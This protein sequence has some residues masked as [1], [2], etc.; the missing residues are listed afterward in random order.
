MPQHGEPKLL[1]TDYFIRLISGLF[2][3][4]SFLFFMGL[5]RAEISNI[6]LFLGI[7]AEPN[8][9]ID[10]S[11]ES[12]M[13][14]AA[15]NDQPNTSTGCGGRISVGG[16]T[17]GPC[18]NPI[19][20][21]LGYFDPKKCYTYN[22]SGYFEPKTLANSTNHSCSGA[23][24]GNMMNWA[25]MTAIDMF[26][27]TM[28]GGNRVIDTKLLTI[29]ERAKKTNN[30]GWFPNKVLRSTSNVAPSSVT[31]W[32]DSPIYIRNTND[33]SADDGWKVT[34]GTTFGGSDKGTYMVRVK[35]CDPTVSLE[36][37]CIKYTSTTGE[38]YYKPEGL[39]QKNSESK[40]FGLMSY[41]NNNTIQKNG[42]V[43]R[44][45]MK[46]VGLKM[47]DTSGNL[48]DNPN[49]EWGTDGL[50][51]TDPDNQ[52]GS[53]GILISG[54]INYINKFTRM[55]GHKGFDPVSELFYEA[56]HYF[57]G[58]TIAH[59]GPTSEY[60]PSNDT[61][62]GR[63]PA[64]SRWDD[65]ITSWCQ[66]N[67]IIAIN[68][69]YAH[70]DK[71]VPGTF[72][73]CPDP[74]GEGDCDPPSN[75]DTFFDA[76]LWTNKIGTLEGFIPSNIGEMLAWSNGVT[77]PASNGRRNTNYVAGLAYQAN[78]KDIRSDLPGKQTVTT[79]M[80]DTQEYNAN[81]LTGNR[82]PLWLTGKYGGFTDTNENGTPD[83]ATLSSPSEW[84]V[85]NDGQ[86]DN[87]VL[88]TSPEKLV[89]G[90]NTVF[91]GISETK[92]SVAAIATNATRLDTD[93]LIYQAKFDS[94]D[95]SGQ[96]I[97]Y[98]INS[99][100]SIDTDTAA[101]KAWDTDQSGLI[102]TAASR[103]IFT[104][105]GTGTP[106]VKGVQFLWDKLSTSQQGYLQASGTVDDGKN[107]LNWLRGDQSKEQ[108]DGIFR[109]R[110]R[111]LGDIIN[112]D[113]FFVNALNFGYEALPGAE[114]SSYSAFRIN[115]LTRTK[116]LYVGAN[117]GMLHAFKAE[118]GNEQFAYIPNAVF[119]NLVSL[120][121]PN[122][123]H[124]YF[125]DGKVYVGD[126]Y[127]GGTW[128]TVLLGTT[129]AGARVVFALD[130]TAPDS[131]DATKVLWEFSDTD[132][133][134]TIG[135]PIIGRM[136]NGKWVAIF[137][138]GYKS[139]SQRA[140][141]FVIDLETGT[142][143][144]KIDTSAGS[145]GAPNGLATPTLIADNNRI[146][147][148][149][150]AGDLLGNLWKFD[151]TATTASNW[152]V[153]YNDGGTPSQ[154]APLFKARYVSSD[155]PPVEVAQPIT[156]P[157]EISLHPS[158]GYLI[159]FGTGKYFEVDDKIST[160]VQS[161]YGIWDQG[162][163]IEETDRSALVRQTITDEPVVNGFTWRV[164]SKNPIDWSIAR[165]WYMDLVTPPYPPGTAQGE[166]VVS[167]PILRYG[168]A[169]FTT[170]IPSL[171]P[172]KGGNG[173]SWIMEV[174][175][176][177]GGR[178]D[179]SVFDVNDDTQ[180]NDADNVSTG[181]DGSELASTSGTQST[182]GIINYPAIIP[183]GPVEYKIGGGTS[184]EIMSIREKGATGS[185]R[186]SWRQLR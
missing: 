89:A 10:M 77:P 28:T 41:A 52:V 148:Y 80:I 98:K 92:A 174:D 101:G 30:D 169:I 151:L 161:L 168:R 65:P 136:Q 157:L 163:R 150:Y 71:R 137:G 147:T 134:Y 114:G 108:P 16:G 35:V 29:V 138:N 153:A 62:Y 59:P 121:A 167:T 133:G 39:I 32:S 119:P 90:L 3:I 115:N 55:H 112:S 97:A 95:W 57:R 102:P 67:F 20:V 60:L 110:T 185:G 45:K 74:W 15:Y 116:M 159:T 76:R 40:R 66:K 14:G 7:G 6:P 124:R 178:L 135:Q 131:F 93:S 44:A 9:L 69:A 113:P 13:G 83:D 130:V 50:Y 11:V 149:A 82:N 127:L 84:D 26:T 144:R 100:G 49:K 165:G 179:Y 1:P 43:L 46:F 86:P 173:T 48:V 75:A 126:A 22:T 103:N 53:H 170:L 139:D 5:A 58:Q 51:I 162:T 91:D 152:K 17:V 164:V 176:V 2:F 181:G 19:A 177:T 128:H 21:Y 96:L 104:W 129:G 25:T 156:A 4:F 172:C 68:D 105:N 63:C 141:L 81:P 12:P 37:N 24:S 140:F 154:P 180:F 36:S 79:F 117:D 31:P 70:R 54:V 27:F 38:V 85:D 146:I 125:V 88:A 94:G 143:I 109:K 142:L 61:E 122:Y 166:R 23:F 33:G 8:V 64:Y 107:R 175:I 160:A 42:G 18:Y 145:V 34:F 132:L 87:Y 118:T 47:P 120:T 99:D 183:A 184:D 56:L 186:Q 78:V 158:G 123:V 73:T 106:L 182:V 155:T 171:D 111:L 72:F